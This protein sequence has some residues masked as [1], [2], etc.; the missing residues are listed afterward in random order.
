MGAL[1]TIARSAGRWTIWARLLILAEIALSLKRH[2]DLLDA[3]EKS[4]LQDI[5]RKSKGKPSN[6]SSRERERL[7][8]LVSKVEPIDLAKEAASGTLLGR[9]RR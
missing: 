8:H 4:E 5:V 9:K 7:K 6:L 3:A 2:Y 1:T